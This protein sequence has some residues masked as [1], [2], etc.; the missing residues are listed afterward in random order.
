MIDVPAH[1]LRDLWLAQLA[2]A[3]YGVCVLAMGLFLQTDMSQKRGPRT[4]VGLLLTGLSL[5]IARLLSLC[6]RSATCHADAV[7]LLSSLHEQGCCCLFSPTSMLHL[8]RC[9]ALA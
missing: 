8:H 3:Y 5:P 4:A 9:M 6:M 2:S 7:L 1:F